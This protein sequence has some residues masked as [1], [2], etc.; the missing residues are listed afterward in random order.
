VRKA[1]YY[2]YFAPN[3]TGSANFVLLNTF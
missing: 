3:F 2:R 1:L